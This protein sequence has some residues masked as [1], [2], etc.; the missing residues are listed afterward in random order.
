VYRSDPE[1]LEW[2]A[3]SSG[4]RKY[5]AGIAALRKQESSSGG[6]GLG[7]ALNAARGRA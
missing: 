2:L 6:G 4:G 3:R 1:Y 7:A 5:A